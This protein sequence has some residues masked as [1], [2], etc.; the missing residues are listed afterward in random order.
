MGENRK[1]VVT[2]GGKLRF[3][4][5]LGTA[6]VKSTTEKPYH[7]YYLE[8]EYTA[9][10]SKRIKWIVYRRYTDFLRLNHTLQSEGYEI[11]TLPPKHLLGSLFSYNFISQRMVKSTNINIPNAF[12]PNLLS[13]IDSTRSLVIIIKWMDN[14]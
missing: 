10:Q 12:I 4:K 11:P 14:I 13:H 2:L 5:I 3:S 8:I 1:P 7:V 6:I 9:V